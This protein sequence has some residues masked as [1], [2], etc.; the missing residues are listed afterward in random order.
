VRRRR[1][2]H[3]DLCSRPRRNQTRQRDHLD[4][5]R[6]ARPT[7]TADD[8]SWDSG[9]R[10]SGKTWTRRFVQPGDYAFH[11]TPHPFMKGVVVVR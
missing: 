8:G 5:Q 4:Q 1:N 9:S 6:S 2:A 7:I 3:H 10:T 11:C